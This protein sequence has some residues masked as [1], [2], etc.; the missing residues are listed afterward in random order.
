MTKSVEVVGAII[1]NENGDI[2][3]ALRSETMSMPNLWEFPG[4]KIE[5]GELPEV[6]LQRE[7]KEELCCTIQVGAL[8]EDT[9]HE[10]PSI[11]V[12]LRTYRAT[13]TNGQP[14]PTEHAELRWVAVTDLRELDWAPADIPAVETIISQMGTQPKS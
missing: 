12:R 1:Q 8:V 6:T 9:T 5:P 4:G 14:T 10:S 11:T 7:I 13:I 3:C 2:L